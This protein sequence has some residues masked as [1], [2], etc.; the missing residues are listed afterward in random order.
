MV[1]GGQQ[2]HAGE[3]FQAL[4]HGLDGFHIQVVCG[5]VQQH[6][7]GA[8]E[9]HFAQHTPDLL[10]AGEN[11]HMLEHVLVGEKHPAQEATEVYIVLLG[12]V[13]PEPVHQ[14]LLVAVEVGGVVLGQVA[15]DGGNAPLD[16]A[17]VGLQLAHEDLE[18][19]CLSQLVFAH[20]GDLVRAA[21]GEIHIVQ[22]LHTVHGDGH[23]LDGEHILAQLPLRHKAHEGIPPGGG[24]HF[25]YAQLVQELPAGGG[26]LGLGLVGGEALN[27]QLQFLDFF[28]VL[29]V[30]V[31]DHSL[32]HLAGFIP[33]VVVAHVHLDLAVVDIHG[34][35]ADGIQEVPVVGD[36]D[37]HA[38]E[39]QQEILQ[40]V[41]G[42]DIQV[43]GGLVQ[44][45]NI[46]VS[47]KRLG[48]EHLHLQTG[49]HAAH[50]LVV[51]LCADAETLQQAGSV[52]LGFP[53]PQ[54][55]K[56]CLQVRG[57]EPIF[58][59]EVRLFVNGILFL[60]HIVKM[61]VAHDDGIHNGEVIV[62]V[63]VLLQYGDPLGGVDLH[64]AGGGVQVP[65]EDPQEGGLARAI[66]T[67]DAVA[68]AGQELQIYMLKQ[69][70]AAELH[71]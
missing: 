50:D 36:G 8:G 48:K 45:D 1:V 43:V 2:H 52:G 67:D 17:L 42:L 15:A 33:E 5:L 61:L 9:H 26:L 4:V 25:F 13:L 12:G 44:H 21:H 64:R 46:R 71:S 49:V 27:E 39:V 24:G 60:H 32:D 11:I 35:G 53:A 20:K 56:L 65:G 66:G 7:V 41:D 68:V 10:T 22:E 59:G 55:R 18:E 16:A 38:G 51:E 54:L 62:G 14:L 6:H 37:D 28:L 3:G 19:G 47:E 69:P 70:L 63:L 29:L 58:V 34:V 57:P 40:P 23:I 31:P 30:L